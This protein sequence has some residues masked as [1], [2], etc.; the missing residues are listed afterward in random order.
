VRVV[1]TDL[2]MPGADG[3]TL[4]RSI[5]RAEA[6]L[7]WRTAILVCSGTPPPV[8]DGQA[9]QYDVYL[10]KPVDL[11]TLTAAFESLGAAFTPG[12]SDLA[13]A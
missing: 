10:P 6:D 12:I 2:T 7:P 8:E 13:A 1:V 4:V 9:R 5:R 3:H 11:Q